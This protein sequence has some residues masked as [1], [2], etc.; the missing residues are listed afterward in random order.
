[1]DD[2]LA[3]LRRAPLLAAAAAIGLAAAPNAA[4][5]SA[6]P[7]EGVTVARISVTV[8]PDD[9]GTIQVPSPF[10]PLAGGD[11][12]AIHVPE[13]EGIFVLEGERILHHFPR[14]PGA[15]VPRD[16]GA[17]RGLLAAGT[18][19]VTDRI[20]ADLTMY[21]LAT[22]RLLDRVTSA[23]PYLEVDFE[24]DDLW[25]VVVEGESVGVYHPG[26]GATYPLWTREARL[27]PSSEQMTG[28][29]AGI[30]FGGEVRLAPLAGGAVELHR[31]AQTV[32]FA[33][34][35]DGEF[36][37]P[38]P[39][40]AALFLQ[41]AAEVRADADGDF[42]LPLEIAVRYLSADGRRADFSLESVDHHVSAR[43]LV[44]RGRAVRVRG[45]RVYWIF[46]GPD[47]LEIRA[48][49]LRAI[50]SVEG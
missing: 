28:A 3:I 43:R 49:D 48:A 16:L 4:A 37:C 41:P 12:I 46:L 26:A 22:G 13:A 15:P 20:T 19:Q 9:D 34:P 27:V 31:R 2:R 39:G 7:V 5:R 29:S 21:D 40:E 14:P 6:K 24:M 45:D 10:T 33:G 32:E 18:P 17:D 11:R 25:R 35:D 50:A 44:I 47:F 42:L 30:G 1:M 8:D 38:A 36:L 23:N